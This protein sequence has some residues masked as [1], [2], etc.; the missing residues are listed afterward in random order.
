[1]HL[2]CQFAC[3]SM[4]ALKCESDCLFVVEFWLGF[5]FSLLACAVLHLCVAL[6]HVL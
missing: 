1:M 2:L 3:I 5:L 4:H 6:Q